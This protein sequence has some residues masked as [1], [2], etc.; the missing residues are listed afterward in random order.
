M[1]TDCLNNEDQLTSI[2]DS[3]SQINSNLENE[4]HIDTQFE[5][6]VIVST[7]YSGV[8]NEDIKV[9]VDNNKSTISAELQQQ[10]FNS[11]SEFP[12]V[13]SKNLVYIDKSTKAIYT[14]N[15]ETV[16]Y[17]RVIQDWTQIES[18]NGGNA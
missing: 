4:S 17:D 9:T 12:A 5:N 13:G 15:S 7:I 11:A 16:S 14:W 8:E 10:W 1:A 18:I 6:V 2:L 3:A